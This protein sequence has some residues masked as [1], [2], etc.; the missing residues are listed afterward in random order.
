MKLH[1]VQISIPRGEEG[2]ARRF[3]GEAL[4]L[5]EVEKPP[6]LAGRGGCWFRAIDGDVITA[7]LHLGVEDP[8]HP[9]E[10]A[11]PGLVLGSLV[12]LEVT[13]DRI[14]RAGYQLSWAERDTF[15][16][17]IR[18]HAHDGF[19]NRVEVMTSAA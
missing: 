11:H 19:G 5:H 2:E 3:Y 7:E 6:S 16:G 14:E 17:Y 10:K 9:A 12:E 8:F 1:H 13:A 18:F 4:G 15:E